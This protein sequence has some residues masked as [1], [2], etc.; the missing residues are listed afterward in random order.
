MF[1]AT[2][3]QRR[4]SRSLVICSFFGA[5]VRNGPSPLRHTPSIH[6]LLDSA[7]GDWLIPL[8]IGYDDRSYIRSLRAVMRLS[9]TKNRLALTADTDIS[10]CAKL[11]P[12]THPI[13]AY[14]LPVFQRIPKLL[15]LARLFMYQSRTQLVSLLAYGYIVQLADFADSLCCSLLLYNW[16]AFWLKCVYCLQVISNF[17]MIQ[18]QINICLYLLY[19]II[20]V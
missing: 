15:K 18:I 8:S 9:S 12:S 11:L 7:G 1:S 20:Q 6:R 2:H 16:F 13:H 3:W 19:K 5:L 10:S 14:L 4:S 17:V